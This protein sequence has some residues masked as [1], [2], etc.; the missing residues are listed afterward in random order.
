[1]KLE[2]FDKT[3]VVAIILSIVFS[4]VIAITSWNWFPTPGDWGEIA[5]IPNSVINYIALLLPQ[6]GI[7][8]YLLVRRLYLKKE[9]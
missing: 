1:M 8:T 6:V 3:A 5:H 2:T 4:L 9:F 7:L